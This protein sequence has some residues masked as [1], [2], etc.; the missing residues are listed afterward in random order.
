MSG[1][2]KLKT[3][4]DHRSNK[5]GCSFPNVQ[6]II[7]GHAPPF[8]Y[9]RESNGRGIPLFVKEDVSA[10]T[11]SKSLSKDFEGFFVELNLRRNKI[12]LCW[13]F[14]SHKSNIANHQST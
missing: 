3:V 11:K 6:F 7:E 14:N 4:L 9:D 13:S 1:N 5:L 12:F 8:R 10:K 2:S